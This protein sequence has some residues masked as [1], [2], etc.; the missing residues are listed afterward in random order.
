MSS[1]INHLDQ[2]KVY[3]TSNR[4]AEAE[5]ELRKAITKDANLIPA[6]IELAYLL[7]MK[8]RAD[9][10]NNLINEIL[11]LLP[12]AAETMTEKATSAIA[13]Q[14]YQN[15][16][17]ILQRALMINPKLLAAQIELAIA[18]RESNNLAEAEEIL[19]KATATNPRSSE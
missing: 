12:N 15:A 14:R 9:E 17:D 4:F 8:D 18:L 11:Q 13:Q 10:S 6:R 7:K 2:A 16:I 5:A 3:L 19:R 1:A